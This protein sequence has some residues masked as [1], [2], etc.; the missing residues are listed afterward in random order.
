MQ[1]DFVKSEWTEDL[2]MFDDAVAESAG[3][4]DY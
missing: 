4:A 2:T 1:T 3:N